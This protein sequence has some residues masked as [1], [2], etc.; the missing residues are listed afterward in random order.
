[1]NYLLPIIA[2]AV[3]YLFVILFKPKKAS[4]IKLFLAFSGAFLLALTVFKLLPEV[5]ASNNKN[6]GLFIMGGIL[7]QIFLEFFSKGAEHGH[8]HVHSPNKT[9]PWLL[10]ISLSVH[11]FLEGIPIHDHDTL[12]LGIII[13][14]VP[15]AIILTLF[16]IQAKYSQKNTLLFL[17][18]FS[19]MTPLGSFAAEEIAF[20]KDYYIE[21]SAI[22]IGIF[23]H[24]STTILFESSEGHKFN[25]AKLVVVIFATFLAYLL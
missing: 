22:V 11:S 20:I 1:M 3:G 15:I 24:V 17:F 14:K 19:L 18:L 8:V 2:I 21:A 6:I 12:L 9:F 23:L 13:H 16:F 5:Y 7:L 10:F 4:N 25:L